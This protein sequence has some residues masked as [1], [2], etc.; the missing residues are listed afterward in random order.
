[1][2]LHGVEIG[3]TRAPSRETIFLGS[4]G[5]PIKGREIVACDER[6]RSRTFPR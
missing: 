5:V 4:D 2:V 3:I 1:M 6:R